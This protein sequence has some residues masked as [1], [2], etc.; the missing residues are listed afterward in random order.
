MFASS[1]E[2]NALGK[3]NKKQ[4]QLPVSAQSHVVQEPPLYVLRLKD[5][6]QSPAARFKAGSTLTD[7]AINLSSQLLHFIPICQDSIVIANGR[8]HCLLPA[9]E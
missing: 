7:V 9:E 2:T 3:K 4:K 6:K 1:D 8:A 5:M